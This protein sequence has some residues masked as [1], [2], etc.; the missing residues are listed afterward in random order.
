MYLPPIEYST[1][2]KKTR[3]IVRLHRSTGHARLVE[4]IR[5]EV[6]R[7]PNEE[8]KVTDLAPRY[9]N[10]SS[11]G[12]PSHRCILTE[13]NRPFYLAE[14]SGISRLQGQLNSDKI[15]SPGFFAR[16]CRNLTMDVAEPFVRM[17]CVGPMTSPYFH[18]PKENVVRLTDP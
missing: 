8:L 18:Q 6:I 15:R 5:W 11:C 4:I 14:D 16:I 7:M 12:F 2:Y 9:G 17:L 3:H 13:S 1:I 10:Q